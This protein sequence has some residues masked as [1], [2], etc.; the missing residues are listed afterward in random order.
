MRMKRWWTEGGVYASVEVRRRWIM[1][2][3]RD[4]LY[5]GIAKLIWASFHRI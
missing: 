2:Y 3:E 5:S 4:L 1:R